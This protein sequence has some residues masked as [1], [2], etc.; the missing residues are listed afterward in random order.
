M[1]FVLLI[2]MPAKVS[3]KGQLVLPARIRKKYGISPGKEVEVLDFS[4][5]IVIVAP[6]EGRGRGILSFRGD[7]TE[8][9]TGVRRKGVVR[10]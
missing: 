2:R 6:P 9:V 8:L 10:P 5:E 4:G 1:Y 7:P 3:T